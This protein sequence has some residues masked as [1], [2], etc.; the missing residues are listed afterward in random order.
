[1]KAVFCYTAENSHHLKGSGNIEKSAVSRGENI[2][3]KKG[4]KSS[5]GN[6]QKTIFFVQWKAR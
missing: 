4:E 6:H 5:N 2:S 3:K 1:V